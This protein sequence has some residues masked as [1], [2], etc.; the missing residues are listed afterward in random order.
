MTT[1]SLD[2]YGVVVGVDGSS[3]SRGAL[4]WAAEWA[5]THDQR[6]SVVGAVDQPS[7]RH[8]AAELWHRMVMILEREVQH[9]SERYPRLHIDRMTAWGSPQRVLAEASGTAWTVVVGT[10]GL[11][12]AGD[13]ARRSAALSATQC[14]MIVVPSRTRD[15]A[16][17]GPV[18]LAG[19]GADVEASAFAF[20]CASRLQVPLVV[21]SPRPT[22]ADDGEQ[23]A[24]FERV[25]PQVEVNRRIIE[26]S[27]TDG[28]CAAADDATLIVV[29][30]A[31]AGA[32]SA[33]ASARLDL[34]CRARRPLA[35][36]GDDLA[37]VTG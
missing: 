6:M 18:V 17:G 15:V 16:R 10:R 20:A 33:R 9:V 35:F 31:R 21:V 7:H 13:A 25:Y 12:P 29:P 23:V 34:L 1:T 24:A 19:D 3:S 5:H 36:V 37:T 28:V 26:D 32:R 27:M 14:P 8:T 30:S 11:Y 4:R 22:A 2:A